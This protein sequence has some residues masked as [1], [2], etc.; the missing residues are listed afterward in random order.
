MKNQTIQQQKFVAYLRTSTKEQQAGLEAQ[1]TSIKAYVK[2]IDGILLES[3]EEHMTGT[4]KNKRVEVY[5]AVSLALQNDATLVVHK[6]DRIARDL[7]FWTEIKRSGVKF[8]ALDNPSG[9]ELLANILMSVA[10][11]EH[12][13]MKTRQREGFAELKKQGVKFGNRKNILNK[14]NRKKALE[15]SIKTRKELSKLKNSQAIG[16]ICDMRDSQV[17]DK[18]GILHTRTW[19]Q[20]ADRLNELNYKTARGKKF[21]PTSVKQLYEV[22]CIS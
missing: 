3:F 22:H 2:S 17:K 6:I 15:N 4:G 10:S 12:N 9:S 20:I 1:R 13:W 7:D 21:F 8:L 19:K 16:Y 5:K 11:A 14:A 18:K